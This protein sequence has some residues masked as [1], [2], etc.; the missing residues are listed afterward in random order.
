MSK[1][2]LIN[3]LEKACDLFDKL[4]EKKAALEAERIIKEAHK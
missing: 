3:A 1:E 2:G 4:Q